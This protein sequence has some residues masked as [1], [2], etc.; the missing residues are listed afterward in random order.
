MLINDQRLTFVE[1]TVRRSVGDAMLE[2]SAARESNGGTAAHAQLLGKFGP[3]YVNAEALIANDFHLRGGAVET[4]KDGRLALDVPFKLGKTLVPAHAEVHITDLPDGSRTLEA[5]SR[6]SVAFNRFDLGATMSYQRNYVATGL[7]TPGEFQ[8]GMLASGHIG[9]VRIRGSADFDV[10]PT[11]QFKDAEL[12]AYWSSSEQSDWEGDLAYDGVLKRVR[13]RI[14]HILRIDTMAIALTG[15]ADTH[16]DIA[17]GF[18]LN[19]S[20]D[21]RHGFTLSRRPLAQGGMVHAT[22]FRD[23]NS[24]GLHDPDEPFEKGVLITTGTLQSE[25]KTDSNGSVTIG[26][27]TAYEPLPVGIDATSL[28]DPMLVPE[29]TLQV[30]TPRPGVPAEVAI[31]LV[32]GGDI[33]GALI[34]SGEIGF[35]GVDL[36]LVDASGK[37]A[38][39]ARTDFDGFFLFDRVAYGSYTIRVNATSATAAKI[40]SD[41]GVKVQVSG[42]RPVARLG[43]IQPHPQPHIASL[44]GA[45]SGAP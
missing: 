40:S 37:V 35:E 9:D 22:V 11:A 15:E 32:G 26:G 1:G 13:A 25:R 30:V 2:V 45:V 21:P 41:L 10:N 8:V 12:S 38:G 20:I 23:L 29:K 6:L 42:K 34:K 14:S 31:G 3:V 27:L 16:G 5:A 39:T 4:E 28:N 7:G 33:E 24:N 19:F 44:G 18:N 36:E 17:A 43:N